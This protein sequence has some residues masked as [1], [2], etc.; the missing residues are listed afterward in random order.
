VF[1]SSVSKSI[2]RHSLFGHVTRLAEDT[3]THQALRCHVDMTLGRF[4]DRIAGDVVQA[5]PATDGSTN[6]TGTT[7]LRLLTSGDEPSHVDIHG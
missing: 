4:P 6:F 3:P 1:G 2:I 5:A 7:T